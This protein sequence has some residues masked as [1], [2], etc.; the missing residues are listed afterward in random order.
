[1]RR[2]AGVKRAR[3]IAAR[4]MDIQLVRYILIG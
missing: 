4:L 3:L 2:R 1:M